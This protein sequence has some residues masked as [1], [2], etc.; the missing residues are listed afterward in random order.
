MG[1]SQLNKI[2]KI[3]N[4]KIFN[5]ISWNNP[6]FTILKKYQTNN[7]RPVISVIEQ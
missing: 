5:N 6:R 7:L 2:L 3:Y 1:K 4:Y